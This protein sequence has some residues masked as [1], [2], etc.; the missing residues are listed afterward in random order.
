MKNIIDTIRDDDDP[1]HEEKLKPVSERNDERIEEMPDEAGGNGYKRKIGETS[2]TRWGEEWLS[3][4]DFGQHPEKT[5]TP[6][7]REVSNYDDNTTT[8]GQPG[9]RENMGGS[10]RWDPNASTGGLIEE[11]NPKQHKK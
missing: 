7:D 3:S 1:K 11:V 6:G 9:D 4:K 2:S 5:R 10:Q 8:V